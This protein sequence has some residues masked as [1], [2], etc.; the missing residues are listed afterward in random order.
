MLLLVS[1]DLPNLNLN[2]NP[3]HLLQVPAT[4]ITFYRKKI[5]QKKKQNTLSFSCLL[6]QNAIIFFLASSLTGGS[7][8]GA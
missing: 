3:H 7:L 6:Y 4:K 8:T 1:L 2:T 5:A